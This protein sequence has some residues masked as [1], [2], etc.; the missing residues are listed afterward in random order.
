MLVQIDVIALRRLPDDRL[1]HVQELRVQSTEDAS[2]SV[3]CLVEK[4]SN[5][6]YQ[7][8]HKFV[9]HAGSKLKP[10]EALRLPTADDRATVPTNLELTESRQTGYSSCAMCVLDM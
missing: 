10:Q 7:V 2:V 6:L 1:L 9:F 4:A 8:S 5:R 3:R